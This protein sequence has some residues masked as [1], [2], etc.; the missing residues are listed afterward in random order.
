VNTFSVKSI[1]LYSLAIG[2]SIVF[3]HL[4]TSYGEAH[5]QAPSAIAGV[6]AIVDPQNLPDCLHQ[7]QLALDLQQSGMYLT[8]NLTT[9]ST[10][11]PNPNANRP[12]LSGRFRD[13][14]LQLEGLVPT[15]IC[16]QLSRIQ[17]TGTIAPDRRLQGRL[18]I[19]KKNP[20]PSIPAAWFVFTATPTTTTKTGT[21]S[22]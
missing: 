18:S 5:L 15:K 2:S 11:P 9:D 21:A 16:P 14:Q 7:S 8:A 22:H 1:G 4:V 12:T 3:F 10:N 20:E 19:V 6:Y 13:R 17:I